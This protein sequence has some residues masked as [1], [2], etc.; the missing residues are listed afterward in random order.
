MLAIAVTLDLMMLAPVMLV[1][2]VVGFLLRSFQI[3]S[4]RSKIRE[5]EAEVLQ[6]HAEI[7]ELQQKNKILQEHEPQHNIPV[8]PLKSKE[9]PSNKNVSGN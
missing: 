3:S 5:L 8:I 1:V 4:L 9:D 7:L 6:S 2:F